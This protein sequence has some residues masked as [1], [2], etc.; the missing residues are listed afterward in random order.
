MIAV[1]IYN[2]LAGVP[3]VDLEIKIIKIFEKT[4]Q[5]MLP[6]PQ[7]THGFPKNNTANSDQ[8]FTSYIPL[9]R[10]QEKLWFE[11]LHGYSEDHSE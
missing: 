8:P 7:G 5:H 11:M 1:K 2:G 4:Q 6:Y 10:L 3:N 9:E